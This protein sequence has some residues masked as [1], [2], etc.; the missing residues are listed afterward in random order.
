MR[1]WWWLVIGPGNLVA[2]DVTTQASGSGMAPKAELASAG[3][4]LGVDT[5]GPALNS[6][7]LDD[8]AASPHLK[9]LS[10]SQESNGGFL[11]R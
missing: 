9:R 5:R 1:R 2:P 7:L 11:N 8:P 3:E 6:W 10:L 4:T